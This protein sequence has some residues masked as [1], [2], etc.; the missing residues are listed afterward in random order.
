MRPFKPFLSPK[1]PFAWNAELQTC[2]ESSKAAI[3]DAI[4]E[5]VTIYDL[6]KT[7][8][9]RSDWSNQGIGYYLSQKHCDCPSN[10]PDCC[11]DGWQVTIAGSRFLTGAEQRYA[12]IEGEAL[13]IAWAL[14]QTKYFTLGCKTLMVATDHKP[15]VE[16]LG[17]KN[18]DQISNPRIFRLKQRTLPWCFEMA[19]LPGKTNSAADA[20]SRH[21]SPN[22][23][24]AEDDNTANVFL[25]GA[26]VLSHHP[27]PK[28]DL[29]DGD[30]TEI[31][32]VGSRIR[33]AVARTAILWSEIVSESSADPTLSLLASA[34]KQGFPPTLRELDSSLAPYWNIRNSL[35]VMEGDVVWYN[36]RL[37][38]PLSL[39]PRALEVLHSAHQGVSCMEDRARGIVYWPGITADIQFTRDS[40]PDCCKNAPSQAPLPAAAPEIPSTPFES[41][42]ADFF[43][44]SGYHYLVAGDRLSGWVE[45]YSS[46]AGSSRAGSSG[47][48]AHLRTLFATFGV[49]LNMSSDGGPELSATATDDFLSRWG[50]HHRESAA[51]NPQSNGRAEVAVKKAKRL[52]KSCIGPVGSLNNDKF[53]R[54]MLQLRNTPDPQCKLSPAQVLFGHPLRDAFSFVNR[55]PKF[56]NRAI[57]P[58]WREAW[59]AKEDALRTRFAGSVEKLNS[60]ARQLPQLQAGERVFIQNQKGTHPNK[61]DRSGV[62]LE[63][64]GHDQYSVKV[65]GTGRITKRNRRFLR[66]YTLPGSP[67]TPSVSHSTAEP[68]FE[69]VAPRAVAAAG[70][71]VQQ[72][73]TTTT[74]TSPTLTA[75]TPV[76]LQPQ[77]AAPACQ[78]AAVVEQQP[79]EVM[80][81]PVPA[82][83]SV[84]ATPPR[85]LPSASGTPPSVVTA[86]PRRTRQQ[87]KQ[88]DAASGKWT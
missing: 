13:G 67:V 28:G 6:N 84:S 45:V 9:L 36:D 32:L 64:L 47:L 62:V 40:C 43:E 26:E 4:K 21:P 31:A 15:L 57:Q 83:P 79:T 10:L 49:P 70:P 1:T 20:T 56:E 24:H 38:L 80:V 66:H 33:E 25:I 41:I 35:V 86:R 17:D 55:C 48:I 73:F 27:S 60:H 74:V 52:L 78:P 46:P 19:Y 81:P 7:T 76:D 11:E 30:R 58:I 68:R 53:L 65:D 75:P 85:Q 12:P 8:C 39:R 29:T 16:I 51:Y 69:P 54:G 14:E 63:S 37:V 18:L 44:A 59:A 87:T 50:V 34:V 3:I 42:F 72:P 2:F 61:W 71:P 22:G 82:D 23:Q 88:Y 5:G 77:P